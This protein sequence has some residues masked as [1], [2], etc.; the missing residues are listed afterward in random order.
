MFSG[1]DGWVALSPNITVRR[2]IYASQCINQLGLPKAD[3]Q[4]TDTRTE[5]PL[6]GVSSGEVGER[7]VSVLQSSVRVLAQWCFKFSAAVTDG[8]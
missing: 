8:K 7:R 6:S 1:F 5:E 2:E 4:A 3:M